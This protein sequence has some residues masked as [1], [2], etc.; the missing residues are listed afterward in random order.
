[1][2]QVL[3]GRT[4]VPRSHSPTVCITL[5]PDWAGGIAQRGMLRGEPAG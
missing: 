5:G 2:S 1:M 4:L 3:S